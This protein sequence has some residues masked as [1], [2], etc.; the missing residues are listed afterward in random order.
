MLRRYP[1]TLRVRQFLP[2]V[3][4]LTLVGLPLISWWWPLAFVLWQVAVVSYATLLAGVAAQKAF[5]MKQ[6]ALI[7]GIPLAIASMHLSWGAAFLWSIIRSVF[8]QA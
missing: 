3:F 5:R 1:H 4:V 6:P 2:P 8:S 7:V